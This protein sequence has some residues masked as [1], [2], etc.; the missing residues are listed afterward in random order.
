MIAENIPKGASAEHPIHMEQGIAYG[1]HCYR[2]PKPSFHWKHDYQFT[3]YALDTALCISSNSNKEVVLQAAEGYILQK[4][5][6]T[7]TYQK[8]RAQVSSR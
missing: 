2:G 7:G 6:L 4:G 1:K 5:M 3:A 8:R